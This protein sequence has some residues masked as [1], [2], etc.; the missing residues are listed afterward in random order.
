MAV[1]N[2]YYSEGDSSLNGQS[3]THT[4]QIKDLLLSGGKYTAKQLNS[5]TG[6]NDARKSI[7]VLRK[8]GYNIVDIKLQ[9]GIKLYWI[10]A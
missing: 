4:D 10:E 2:L 5:I 6:G 7:S 1:V 8:E 3:Y 9:R